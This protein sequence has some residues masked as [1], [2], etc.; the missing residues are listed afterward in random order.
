M[1]II[2]MNSFSKKIMSDSDMI[3]GN[4]WGLNTQQIFGPIQNLKYS[5]NIEQGIVIDLYNTIYNSP[6]NILF[7]ELI[8]HNFDPYYF[9]IK[10]VDN[11]IYIIPIKSKILEDLYLSNTFNITIKVTNDDGIT[12]TNYLDII[13]NIEN[14]IKTE[15]VEIIY[16][17]EDYIFDLNFLNLDQNLTFEL[18][19]KNGLLLSQLEKNKFLQNNKIILS[20][21][22]DNEF[23][24]LCK[25]SSSEYLIKIIFK[26]L[27]E[28]INSTIIIR[29]IDIIISKYSGRCL[30]IFDYIICEQNFND[31]ILTDISQPNEYID[32]TLTN[33]FI[34]I[35]PNNNSL[36]LKE[37]KYL[38][39]RIS[40]TN[41][42]NYGYFNINILI[43]SNVLVNPTS[44][45]PFTINTISNKPIDNMY[46]NNMILNRIDT[47]EIR[48]IS[49]SNPNIKFSNIGN[50]S[51]LIKN[52]TITEPFTIGLKYNN[53]VYYSTINTKNFDLQI[54]E[55]LFIKPIFLEC[56]KNAGDF[57]NLTNYIDTNLNNYKN[58]TFEIDENESIN[59]IQNT[60]VIYINDDIY[61]SKVLIN[62]IVYGMIK[63]KITN[64]YVDDSTTDDFGNI[65]GYRE[66]PFFI[67]LS[68]DNNDEYLGSS[69]IFDDINVYKLNETSESIFKI[70]SKDFIK[71]VEYEHHTQDISGF[72]DIKVKDTNLQINFDINPGL[73]IDTQLNIFWNKDGYEITNI[74]YD[75]FSNTDPF[76]ILELSYKDKD[77]N[78]KV[79]EQRIN[80][81]KKW[82][83]ING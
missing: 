72:E 30:D 66:I 20:K 56:L 39:K 8:E 67:N 28:K 34:N 13:Y 54:K 58:I 77:S 53:S 46:V 38:V 61:K 5:L 79:Y 80:F 15:K 44:T 24:V 75:I 26:D 1:S 60:D 6:F 37:S 23:I 82:E 78:I 42:I 59:L 63:L 32:L 29:D 83:K 27:S 69:L 55:P 81:Y 73:L 22:E 4:G 12:I 70:N 11:L 3:F 19:F 40:Y 7:F 74:S 48:I 17:K 65:Y 2:Q 10:I 41:G 49:C 31:I 36:E 76:I 18:V 45:I 21:I 71:N 62:K 47:N 64:I 33:Q 68:N 52:L 57:T 16:D 43:D 9:N 51:I 25:N 14:T 50:P 35:T